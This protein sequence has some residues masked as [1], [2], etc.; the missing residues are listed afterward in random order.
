MRKLGW[1]DSRPISSSVDPIR[2][3]TNDIM[4]LVWSRLMTTA[5][6]VLWAHIR[7]K[8][9]KHELFDSLLSVRSGTGSVEQAVRV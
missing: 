3:K 5:Q 2:D 8:L 4:I 9:E 6:R 1:C 7:I